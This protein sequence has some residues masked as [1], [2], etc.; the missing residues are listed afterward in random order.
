MNIKMFVQF[1]ET[2]IDGNIIKEGEFQKANS[3]LVGFI[4]DYQAHVVNAAT[5][6][7]AKDTAGVARAVPQSS[8][9]NYG[10]CGGAGDAAS[11]IVV[12]TNST[13]VTITD[14]ALN[15]KV[16]NGT[17]ANQLSYAGQTTPDTSLTVS[18]SEAYFTLSRVLTNSSGGNITIKEVGIISR[19]I[20][21]YLLMDRTI[22]AEYTV[23]NGA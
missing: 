14:Y 3:L 1:S 18:G 4:A 7:V 2:D 13:A 15:T 12:G 11:G 8:W 17:G 22:P 10:T 20:S 6:A 23:N 21:Q 16:A 5:A 9:A 19:V